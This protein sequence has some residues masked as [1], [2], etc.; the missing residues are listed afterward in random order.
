MIMLRTCSA[1]ALALALLSHGAALA[2]E[3]DPHLALE[4]VE[5]PDS[6]AWVKTQNDKTLPVL[7]GDPRF[8]GLQAEALKILSAK[9]RIAQPNFIGQDV[10]NFWQDETHVRGVWRR[11]T[12]A[13]YKTATPQWETVLD[14]DALAKAEGKNW[15]WKGADCRPKTHDRCLLNLSNGGKDAVTVRE[16]DLTTKAFVEGGFSLPEGKQTSSGWTPTP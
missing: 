4:A 6:L 16:F 1:G 11:T 15:I 10:F 3:S 5:S 9:D 8:A 2:Q 13:S 12:L 14:L 7:S